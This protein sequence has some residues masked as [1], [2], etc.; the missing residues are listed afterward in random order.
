MKRF[1]VVMLAGLLAMAAAV[2]AQ[3]F[4][5]SRQSTA[6]PALRVI[7]QRPFTVQGLHFRSRER[8]KVML[9]KQ[10][11][12]VRTRRVTA[13]SRGAFQAVLQEAAVD[14]CDTI[15]VRAVGTRGSTA[16]LKLLPRPACRST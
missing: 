16:V 5:S 1:P 14:R 12:S 3:G 9:Y 15:M 13:S 8:V 7:D 11:A 6:R 2:T 10:Q 4:A